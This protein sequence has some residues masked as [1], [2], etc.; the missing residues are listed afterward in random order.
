MSGNAAALPSPAMNSRRRICR[1]LKLTLD[2]LPRVGLHGNGVNTDAPRDLATAWPGC[3]GATPSGDLCGV[4][5]PGF[6]AFAAVAPTIPMTVPTFSVASLQFGGSCSGSRRA[7]H[8]GIVAQVAHWSRRS[9][10]RSSATV[11]SSAGATA[12]MTRRAS[13]A[14]GAH[15]AE[16]RHGRSRRKL[17]PQRTYE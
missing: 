2:S 7:G 1:P 5:H 10:R 6:V 13:A 16:G 4:G 8:L 15:V 3:P 11:R 9:R 12:S 14:V 17:P